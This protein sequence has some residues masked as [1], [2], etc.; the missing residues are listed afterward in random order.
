MATLICTIGIEP[1]N[2]VQPLNPGKFDEEFPPIL[3]YCISSIIE[4]NSASI[5]DD[6]MRWEGEEIKPS[7]HC[8][9]IIIV[10]CH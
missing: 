2:I 10:V 6:E 4:S 3:Q 5:K 1:I 8:H 9:I 7:K